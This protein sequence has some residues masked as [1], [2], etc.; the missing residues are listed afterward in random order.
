L[1]SQQFQIQN[2]QGLKPLISRQDQ[3]LLRRHDRLKGREFVLNLELLLISSI[4][5]KASISDGKAIGHPPI[6][7]GASEVIG[8]PW[9]GSGFGGW[10]LLML[11][12]FT[13]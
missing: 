4:W 13:T 10:I 5:R 8:V 7:L 9:V 12:S 6:G 11:V 3:A 1:I 2:F